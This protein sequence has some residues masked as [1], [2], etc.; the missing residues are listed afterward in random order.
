MV[1]VAKGSGCSVITI[2][3]Y[4]E[5]CCRAVPKLRTLAMIGLSGGGFGASGPLRTEGVVPKLRKFHTSMRSVTPALARSSRTFSS[6]VP[7]RMRLADPNRIGT[8]P[9]P[10]RNHVVRKI[11]SFVL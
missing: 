8:A 1:F 3:L 4:R 5:I 6:T 11:S 10:L 7:A 2:S 9:W